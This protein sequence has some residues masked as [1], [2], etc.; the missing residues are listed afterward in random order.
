MILYKYS[1][2]RLKRHVIRN[3][4]RFVRVLAHCVT[5]PEN[6]SAHEHENIAFI[7]PDMWS[8]ANSPD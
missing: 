6:R 2:N 8:A 5:L 3:R 4:H 7:E 1:F